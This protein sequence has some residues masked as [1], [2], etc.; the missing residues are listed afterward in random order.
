MVGD[1]KK[2]L[3]VPCDDEALA[4]ECESRWGGRRA[5][6]ERWGKRSAFS[7]RRPGSWIALPLRAVRGVG[8]G[9]VADVAPGALLPKE[10]ISLFIGGPIDEER[11]AHRLPPVRTIEGGEP[12]VAVAVMLAA[13]HQF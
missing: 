2:G 5:R 4:Q 13:F 7:P 12:D 1:Q 8:G 10:P 6:T 3:A 11:D 9:G